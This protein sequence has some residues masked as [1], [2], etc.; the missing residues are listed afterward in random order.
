MNPT[1]GEILDLINEVSNIIIII[2]I[3]MS[4]ISIQL[5]FL[6]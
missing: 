1:E 3:I 5:L 4:F 2:I 6:V